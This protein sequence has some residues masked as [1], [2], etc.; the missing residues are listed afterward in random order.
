[1]GWTRQNNIIYF[2]S[3]LNMPKIT[4]DQAIEHSRAGLVGKYYQLPEI[5]GGTTFAYAIFTGEHGQRS[6]GERARIYYILKGQ[7]KFMVNQEEFEA[8]AGDLVTIPPQAT[9]NLWPIGEAVEVILVSELLDLGNL[10]K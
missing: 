1:M 4:K 9:Y 8:T 5:S 2:L 7:V 3:Y 10:P 6:I